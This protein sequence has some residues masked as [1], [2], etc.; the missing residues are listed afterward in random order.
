MAKVTS[1]SITFI[2]HTGI[3]KY[4]YVRYSDDG[5]TFTADGGKTPGEWLGTCSTNSSTAPTNF[6]DYNWS[7]VKGADGPSLYTWIKY[8]DDENGTNMSDNPDG[9]L[10]MGIAYN[11]TTP[12][13]STNPQDYDS[14]YLIT[15]RGI[16]RIEEY[17]AATARADDTPDFSNAKPNEIP[18]LNATDK[19]YLWNK[20]VTYFT[21]G[22]DNGDETEAIIIGVYGDTGIGIVDV[23]NYYTT[24]KT[25][26]ESP[27]FP[28]EPNDAPKVDAE[29]K[30][31]WNYEE[32]VYTE[33][34]PTVT[35]PAIIG[36]YG[37]EGE[38]GV[39]FDIY[40]S[41][42]SEFAENVGGI[43]IDTIVLKLS[44]FQGSKPI[45]DATCTWSWIDSNTNTKAILQEDK[46]TKD[47]EVKITDSWALA[48]LTCE[49]MLPDGSGPYIDTIQ[50]KKKV[51]VYT[52]SIK[53]FDGDNVFQQGQQF[54]IGYIDLY[55]NGSLVETVIN[56]NYCNSLAELRSDDTIKAS[57][58]NPDDVTSAFFIYKVPGDEDIYDIVLGVYDSNDG[59]W[60]ASD[61][62]T[63][64][65]YIKNNINTSN[66][67]NVFVVAKNAVTRNKTV[68]VDVY[69]SQADD[70]SLLDSKSVNIIDLNDV[71][72]GAKP[73][74]P[75]YDGQ[76]WFDTENNVLRIY[77]SQNSED[78]WERSSKQ[79]D[80]QSVH[81]S[82]PTSYKEGDLW[83]LGD[84]EKIEKIVGQET[85]VYTA[86]TLV[87]ATCDSVPGYEDGHW[88]DTMENVTNVVNNVR[89]HMTFDPVTGLRIGQTNKKFYVNIGATRMSFCEDSTIT[90]DT[91]NE[92]IDKNEVVYI[93]NKSA[94]IRELNVDG[95]AT[96][97]GNAIFEK[98]I[99]FSDAFTLM[100]DGT[101]LSLVLKS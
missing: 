68:T 17:Y 15:H 89:Q 13:E 93:G 77:N 46:P 23:K 72:V 21:D 95:T 88:V 90:A 22:D 3:A 70:A 79:L 24:T 25:P 42:E 39:K 56:Q 18:E 26:D 49:M 14:W 97:K 28:S 78:P 51:D 32:I 4:F 43:D 74:E 38:A 62:K 19:K 99:Y 98:D 35:S 30:Y 63:K 101:G 5:E 57:Y 7:K 10:Y 83:I 81:T 20:E 33:G 59:T 55:K 47:F 91:T 31:L 8:A 76:L 41:G 84:N 9:K 87:R 54:M 44:A 45:A 96:L 12:T 94:T 86:G 60:K 52:A 65:T 61:Y 73:S 92:Y 11:K 48:T 58:S 82:K 53:F 6:I 66:T 50:L 80:G 27:A 1:N 40:C 36:V 2:D 100:L 85:V 29:Y 37:D 69:T 67:S 64:Y 16:D 34:E 75:W 71:S